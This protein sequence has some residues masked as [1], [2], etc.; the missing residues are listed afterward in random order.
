MFTSS[1]QLQVIQCSQPD[2]ITSLCSSK[3]IKIVTYPGT[4]VSHYNRKKLQRFADN[5]CLVKC[6][7]ARLDTLK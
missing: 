1:L 4:I 2:Y 5:Y 7:F 3:A 6:E